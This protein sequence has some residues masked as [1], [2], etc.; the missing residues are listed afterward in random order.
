MEVLFLA[1]FFLSFFLFLLTNYS[2][3]RLE[4]FPF[5]RLWLWDWSS[6]SRALVTQY[7]LR[8]SR[9]VIHDNPFPLQFLHQVYVSGLST[10]FTRTGMW[11][12]LA[13]NHSFLSLFLVSNCIVWNSSFF[14]HSSGQFSLKMIVPMKNIQQCGSPCFP[15]P[16][17]FWWIS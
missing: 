3:Q 15:H 8:V 6:L 1:S 9:E 14:I 13:V 11:I 12:V 10:T 4:A 5:K 2:T 16:S 17:A 7:W